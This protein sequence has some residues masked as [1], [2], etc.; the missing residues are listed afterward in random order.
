MIFKMYAQRKT[1][2]PTI[3]LS[4]VVTEVVLAT[5]FTA[6]FGIAP[7]CVRFFFFSVS[8]PPLNKEGSQPS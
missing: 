6:S 7:I 3:Y 4:V 2:L 8:T 5:V 1:L